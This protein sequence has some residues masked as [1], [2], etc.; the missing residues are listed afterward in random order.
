VALLSRTQRVLYSYEETVMSSQGQFPISHVLRRFSSALYSLFVA[1]ALLQANILHADSLQQ[2]EQLKRETSQYEYKILMSKD[3]RV[4]TYML[5]LYNNDLQKYGKIH[6]SIHPEFTAIPWKHGKYTLHNTESGMKFSIGG[7]FAKFDINNDG[8]EE[9]IFK[10][11]VPYRNLYGEELFVF[12]DITLDF[13]NNIEFTANEVRRF[14]GIRYRVQGYYKIDTS[15]I[16]QKKLTKYHIEKN[17]ITLFILNPF[18]LD[19]MYYIGIDDVYGDIIT[20]GDIIVKWQNE[21]PKWHVIAKYKD[22]HDV[23]SEYFMTSKIEHVCYF[24]KS[25][26][27]P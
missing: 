16:E 27:A 20:M 21:W 13:S 22:E 1:L 6:Y 17:D 23:L 2:D 15:L 26:K 3:A 12:D 19:G 11:E 10:K 24:E 5:T 8:K 18:F 25:V 7:E 14:K 9:L 4:C